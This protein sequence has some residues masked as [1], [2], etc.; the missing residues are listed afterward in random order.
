[1]KKIGI[2]TYHRAINYGAVLQCYALKKICENLGF[3]VETIDYNPF[4]HYTY[5]GMLRHKPSKSIPTIRTFRKLNKFVKTKLNPTEHTEDHNY[6]IANPPKDDIY[7]VGSDQIWSEEIAGHLLPSYLLDFAPTHIKRIAYAPSIGGGDT[8]NL[9]YQALFTSELP[10]FSA[11]SVREK[12]SISAI[13]PLCPT[14]VQDVCDPSLLLTREDYK[15]IEKKK[16]TPKHYIVTFDLSSSPLN[17]QT[18]IE[19]KKRT[20]L[21]IVNIAPRIDKWCDVNY[22]GLSPCEWLYIM[23][24]ADYIV[25]N[26]FHGVAFSIIFRKSFLYTKTLS[27]NIS[28]NGRAENLLSQTN[29]MDRFISQPTLPNIID[30]DYSIV[31]KSIEEYRKRSLNWLQSALKG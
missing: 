20:S 4:G 15:H 16:H 9:E 17:K 11:V 5:K 13:Q 27:G 7:I 12:Q 10:K 14:P 29:L 28:K 19:L 23:H 1:M 8:I 6:I 22:L 30:I 25:T 31:N 3:E 2:L 24:N 21:R 26:S 18:A